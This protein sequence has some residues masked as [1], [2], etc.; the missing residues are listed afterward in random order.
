MTK[1]DA[2]L[3]AAERLFSRN[4][5]GLTGVDAARQIVWVNEGFER[6]SGFRL[7]EVQGRRPAALFELERN[8]PAL[9][10]PLLAALEAGEPFH[11]ELELQR[12]SGEFFWA[13]LEAQP[14]L[15]AEGR[16]DGYLSWPGQVMYRIAG[17]KPLAHRIGMSGLDD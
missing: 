9:R 5:F 7:D 11:G 10:D 15:D 14:L 16:L 6:V 13:E 8:A 4:G 17:P 12:K 2:I 1:R 3:V